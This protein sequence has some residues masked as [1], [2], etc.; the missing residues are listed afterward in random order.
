MAKA[1]ASMDDRREL[2]VGTGWEGYIVWNLA[3]RCEMEV[4]RVW[5]A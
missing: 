1:A 2:R 5:I 4:G 3:R